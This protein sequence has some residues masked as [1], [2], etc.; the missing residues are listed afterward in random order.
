MH[1]ELSACP[2]LPCYLLE[3]KIIRPPARRFQARSSVGPAVS[4]GP[5]AGFAA[6]DI[7]ISFLP[8]PNTVISLWMQG[9][10]SSSCKRSLRIEFHLL[11]VTD[12]ASNR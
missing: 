8:V 10:I 7:P 11:V 6:V 1:L 2:V 3:S 12:L 4:F 9:D 5:R